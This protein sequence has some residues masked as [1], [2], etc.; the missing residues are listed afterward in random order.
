MCAYIWAS[1]YTFAGFGLAA[2]AVALGA[3]CAWAD[4]A[5]EVAG[6][7]AGRWLSRRRIPFAALTL[8]HVVLAVDARSLA[9]LRAHERVHVRQYE[10]WGALFGPVYLLSSAWQAVRGADPYRSNR[11]ERQ[12]YAVAGWQGDGALAAQEELRDA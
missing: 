7:R 1:P 8:G 6:G 2:L 3:R 9:A 10:R 4:G 5:L 11:F 12:A